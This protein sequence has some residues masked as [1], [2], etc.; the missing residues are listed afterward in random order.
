MPPR[1][2]AYAAAAAALSLFSS[3]MTLHDAAM[4]PPAF[5]PLYAVLLRLFLLS[6]RLMKR[7]SSVTDHDMRVMLS[8]TM[9][10]C[11]QTPRKMRIR[12]FQ[13]PWR[14]FTCSRMRAGVRRPSAQ[15]AH[16]PEYPAQSRLIVTLHS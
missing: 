16:H 5:R 14:V 10:Q 13:I 9:R 4:P 8:T 12:A 3:A 6:P 7:V 1:S 15:P 2:S 11:Q